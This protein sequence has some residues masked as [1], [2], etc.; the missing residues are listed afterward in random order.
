MFIHVYHVYCMSQNFC[1]SVICKKNSQ[2]STFANT[3]VAE[4]FVHIRVFIMILYSTSAYV[5][6]TWASIAAGTVG[7]VCAWCIAMHG[8]HGQERR[9]EQVDQN[10]VLQSF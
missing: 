2:M 9:Q 10:G 5:K 6:H 4:T 3:F 8:M 7:D 1:K